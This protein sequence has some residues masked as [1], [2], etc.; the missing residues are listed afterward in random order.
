MENI[1]KGTNFGDF[2]TIRT[3]ASMQDITVARL[4]S[5]VQEKRLPSPPSFKCNVLRESLS[6]DSQNNLCAILKRSWSWV[7]SVYLWFMVTLLYSSPT[8]PPLPPGI[9]LSAAPSIA[10][11]SAIL[12]ETITTVAGS[13]EEISAG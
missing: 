5:T 13:Q 11:R 8:P 7:I 10:L 2:V 12:W 6:V 4:Q 1:S 3:K 9:T